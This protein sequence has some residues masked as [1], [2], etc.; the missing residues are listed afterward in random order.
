MACPIF[1]NIPVWHLIWCSKCISIQDVL[2]YIW[3]FSISVL[4]EHKSRLEKSLKTE[5]S[6]HKKTRDGKYLTWD[7]KSLPWA[8]MI[9][10]LSLYSN[11]ID[12][13]VSH[14]WTCETSAGCLRSIHPSLG[15]RQL[16]GDVTRGQWRHNWPTQLRDLIII[17][18]RVNWDLYAFKHT[19]QRIPDT[20]ML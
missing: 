20:K 13:N 14:A 6:A 11:I 18:I 9:L 4:F 19:Q 12:N 7:W 16:F 10:N 1:A 5:E 17:I 3:F 15:M 8:T 2:E